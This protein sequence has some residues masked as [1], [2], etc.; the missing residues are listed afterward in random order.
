MPQLPLRHSRSDNTHRYVDRWRRTSSEKSWLCDRHLAES[1][2]RVRV[3]FDTTQDAC[4]RAEWGSPVPGPRRWWGIP[5]AWSTSSSLPR[6]VSH[7][8]VP[9]SPKDPL[10]NKKAHIIRKL[11]NWQLSTA[12]ERSMCSVLRLLQLIV[13]LT[14]SRYSAVRQPSSASFWSQRVEVNTSWSVS[15]LTMILYCTG[16]HPRCNTLFW[17][18]QH[19][20]LCSE[21]SC[22]CFPWLS[23][24][25][26]HSTTLECSAYYSAWRARSTSRSLE[27]CCLLTKPWVVGRFLW[28]F[29]C[30]QY[31]SCTYHHNIRIRNVSASTSC[32]ALDISACSLRTEAGDITARISVF[33]IYCLEFWLKYWMYLNLNFAHLNLKLW[34]LFSG[35]SGKD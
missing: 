12:V 11:D 33:K 6:W 32:S 30:A 23:L 13:W 15:D 19:F 29:I 27:K 7:W 8:P 24:I 18:L 21:I 9:D 5:S 10:R 4:G 16:R 34:P 3:R 28:T 17:T 2:I 31:Y 14:V 26:H 22:E 35:T 20:W 25:W 1:N